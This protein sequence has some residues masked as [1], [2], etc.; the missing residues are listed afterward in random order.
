MTESSPNRPFWA[1]DQEGLQAQIQFIQNEIPPID[2][3]AFTKAARSLSG[4]Q[5]LGN[6]LFCAL[7]R[8]VG[9]ECRLV[10][11]LQP[12]PFAA[13]GQKLPTPQ[14]P[15]KPVIYVDADSDTAG[16]TSMDDGSVLG[17]ANEASPSKATPRPRRR[18]GQ[19]SIGM[20]VGSYQ[21]AAEPPAK[22][23]KTVR[24]LDYPVFWT[25]AFNSAYQ[26]WV[27]VDATV[28]GTVGKPNR[29]E[30][31]VSYD[32]TQV[33]YIVAFEEDGVAKDVTRRY[34]KAYNAK[35]RKTRIEATEGGDKWWKRVMRIFRRPGMLVCYSSTLGR[36]VLTIT[37]PRSGR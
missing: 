2:K 17:S 34:A 36:R 28:T 8:A 11:S 29:F 32:P 23:R 14:K 22:K 1:E 31:P 20:P 4:S 37:G 24:K 26:K 19:P 18:I 16:A 7:L 21:Q 25:E 9:V 12:L 13:I 33:S 27:P 5:D 15:R 35:T 6:Q 3:P 30:P 10:C